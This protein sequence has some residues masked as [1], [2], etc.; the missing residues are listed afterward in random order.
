MER[1]VSDP[2]DGDGDRGAATPAFFTP[3]R[4][5]PL[6]DQVYEQLLLQIGSGRLAVGG[7][8]PSEPRLCAAFGVSR[9]VV[10]AAL[11]RLRADGVV[12]SRRG[13]GSFVLRE[14]SREFLRVAPSGSIA[15]LMRCY[16]MRVALEGEAAF[17]AAQRRGAAELAAMEAA[18]RRLE[19]A[20]A[21]ND[22][23]ADADVAFHHAVAEATHNHLFV[24]AMESM[25]RPLRDGI[26]TAR[27]LSQ[28]AAAERLTLVQREHAAI[29]D[30]VRAGDG[31]AARTAM[32]LHIERSRDRMVGFMG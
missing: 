8:L 32:R 14:P 6:P 3:H 25:R 22:I 10:R 18:A 1:A 9:P 5:S 23:G 24:Q 28:M 15:E 29:L 17:L 2:A 4:Q 26:A 19:Q 12:E 31:E 13:S 27:R 21:A 7:R 20:I 16:E 30:A 11:A